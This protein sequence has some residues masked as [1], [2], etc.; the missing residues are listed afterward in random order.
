MA[1]AQ[2]TCNSHPDLVDFSNGLPHFTASL[3]TKRRIKIVAMGSSSTAGEGTVLPF[4]CRLEIALRGLYGDRMID[5][6]NRGLG[7]QEAPEEAARFES[8]VIA[9][10]PS[11]VI[12]QVG[13]N[14]IYHRDSYDPPRVAGTIATGL[15][16]LKQLPMDV[17][18]MDMQYASQLLGPKEAD[19]RH[20]VTLISAVARDARVNLFPRFTLMERWVKQDGIDPAALIEADGLHQTEFATGCVSKALFEA[21]KAAVGP[22]PGAPLP[23]A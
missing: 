16:W 1:D 10:A 23:T 8:D 18:L 19:T 14:A 2:Q 7:G 20:L 9:E 21:I 12:W 15:S 5:V 6:L 22:V 17:I 13:T 11:L 3:F 4:P